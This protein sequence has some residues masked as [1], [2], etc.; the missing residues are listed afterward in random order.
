MSS[1]KKNRP[2][3]SVPDV[4]TQVA[5]R[6]KIAL[7]TGGASGIGLAVVRRFVDDG[8]R[9]VVGDVD[10]EA[11]GKVQAE[12][13]AAVRTRRCDVTVENDVEALAATAVEEFDGLEVAFANAG[14]G[15]SVA[16]ADADLTEWTRVLN[17]NLVGSFL[18]IKHA[19]PRMKRGGSIVVTTSLNA[20]QPG[21]GMSAYCASKAGAKMLVEV[22]ALELG[23]SG[24]R[25]NAIGPGLVRTP[26]TDGMWFLPAIVEEFREN[27]P[28]G[29]HASPEEIANLVA[30][31]SSDEAS[32]ISGSF[33]LVDGGAHT[34]RYPDIPARIAEAQ[35]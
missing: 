30:F 20:V 8:M 25:V 34:M 11:L 21:P 33:Y 19:A 28:L 14:I 5:E 10:D 29:T 23:P 1:G 6:L 18:T 2:D 3:S 17:V 22:A 35:S 12:L 9:V 32:F 24:I 31:L 27:T 4:R 15:A 13:G 16:I 26:L 7:V